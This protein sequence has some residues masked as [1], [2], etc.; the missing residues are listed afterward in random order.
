M[1]IE[2]VKIPLEQSAKVSGRHLGCWSKQRQ[3][4]QTKAQKDLHNFIF[5]DLM[6]ITITQ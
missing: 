2:A 5:R 3:A 1:V 4:K 6:K